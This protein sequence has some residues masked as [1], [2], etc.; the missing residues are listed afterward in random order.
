MKAGVC[1][2]RFIRHCFGGQ[3]TYQEEKE[4][5]EEESLCL[6]AT[7]TRV[8]TPSF[9]PGGPGPP[10]H[11]AQWPVA[12]G[13]WPALRHSPGSPRHCP[14]QR[15]AAAGRKTFLAMMR[16]LSHTRGPPALMPGSRA[17]GLPSSSKPSY[18]DIGILHDLQRK[19]SAISFV[20]QYLN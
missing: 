3:R 20:K 10:R 14:A 7:A 4:G 13:Q 2:H 19:T 5:E 11:P 12:S 6:R 1:D 18:N 16:Y 9:C 17:A 15:L 8:Q